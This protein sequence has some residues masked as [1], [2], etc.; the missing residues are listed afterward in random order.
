[1]QQIGAALGVAVVGVVFFGVIG[2]TYTQAQLEDGITAGIWVPV[3]GYLVAAA[4]TL[5]LPSQAQVRA[6]PQQELAEA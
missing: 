6:R 5:L 3:V 1:M 2:T 4:A